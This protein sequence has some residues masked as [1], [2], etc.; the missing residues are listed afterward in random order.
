MGSLS[1]PEK[2]A[3]WF[4]KLVSEILQKGKNASLNIDLKNSK[5]VSDVS[6]QTDR[7]IK[8][9]SGLRVCPLNALRKLKD[10]HFI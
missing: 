4:S 9:K 7:T 10:L 6:H 2:V 3:L 5:K 8:G 1:Q